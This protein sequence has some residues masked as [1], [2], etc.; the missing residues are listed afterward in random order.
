[1]RRLSIPRIVSEI[2]R[3]L[4]FKSA[5]YPVPPETDPLVGRHVTNDDSYAIAYAQQVETVPCIA[6]IYDMQIETDPYI[7]APPQ[8]F[9]QSSKQS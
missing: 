2:A 7:I 6:T 5:P 8:L 4:G 9:D 1:M 3:R